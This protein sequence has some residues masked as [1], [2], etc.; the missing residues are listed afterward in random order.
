A[1]RQR[2]RILRRV[3]SSLSFRQELE[4]RNRASC[5]GPV[6]HPR[7]NSWWVQTLSSPARPKTSQERP[8]AGF[9]HYI[10]G[11]GRLV[12][13]SGGVDGGTLASRSRFGNRPG[14]SAPF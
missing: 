8:V 13:R 9:K 11:S 3:Y 4:S 14:F 10:D 2:L 12:V 6:Y 5:C 1:N 7:S